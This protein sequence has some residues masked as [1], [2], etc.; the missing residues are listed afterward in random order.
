MGV[1][2]SFPR[3]SGT[4]EAMFMAGFGHF[5]V[6]SVD[7]R[8]PPMTGY[9]AALDDAMT[10]WKA[11]VKMLP[12]ENLAI[13]VRRRGRPDFVHGAASKAG[14][15]ASAGGHCPLKTDV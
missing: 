4:V 9:P 12:P 7:Y 3:A 2:S 6:I 10:V 5:K 14:R 11:A 15:P 8:M 1:V 13:L